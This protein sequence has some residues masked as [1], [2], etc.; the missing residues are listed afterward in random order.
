MA[1]HA[2][3]GQ[4]GRPEDH[5]AAM[6]RAVEGDLR[7]VPMRA[8]GA[9]S[10]AKLWIA[11]R[12]ASGDRAYGLPF[13]MP[14]AH[15]IAELQADHFA[16]DLELPSDVA[17]WSEARLIAFL[18]SGGLTSAAPSI[19]VSPLSIVTSHAASCSAGPALAE[20]SSCGAS[21]SGE[22]GGVQ[23]SAE[24]GAGAPLGRRARVACLHGTAGNERIF[25]LQTA[26]LLAALQAAGAGV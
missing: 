2:G 15:R 16:E 19:A 11:G 18:E 23:S 24:G 1:R 5:L 25:R 12:H 17:G 20:P 14:S 7:H 10:L 13:R 9:L 4:A 26:R 22:N 3:G 21:A 6:A 8:Q